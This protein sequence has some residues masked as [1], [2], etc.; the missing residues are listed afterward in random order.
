MK[1]TAVGRERT[2]KVTAVGRRDEDDGSGEREMFTVIYG[3]RKRK[4]TAKEI[5]GEGVSGG[6][7]D[8]D[9]GGLSVKKR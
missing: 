1:M 6:R 4:M 7:R 8:E 9:D 5:Y 3:G 2:K